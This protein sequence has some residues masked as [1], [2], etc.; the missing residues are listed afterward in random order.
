M[1]KK[2]RGFSLIEMLIVI[3]IACVMLGGI[4]N[5]YA[6]M[7]RSVKA[8]REQTIIRSLTS[9]YL[10]IVRNLPYSQVGTL[11]GNPS[12]SLADQTNPIQVTIQGVLYKI[13]YEVTYIDDTADGTI[14]LATDVAPNDFKQVKMFIQNTATTVVRSFVTTVTPKGLEGLGSGGALVI[15]VFDSQGQPVS[16]AS[17]HIE[18]LALTPDIILD[19][20]TDA[21]GTWIEVALPASVNGYHIVS[22]K[23]GYSTDQTYPISGGNPN[24]IKPDSTILAGQITQVSFQ[25][26]RVSNLTIRTLNSTCQNLSNVDVNLTGAKLI[27]TSPN[28]KKF[29]QNLTSAAGQIALT[30]I[31]WD[32][33]T[34]ILLTGQNLMTLG[35]S[36][37]QQISV[38]ANSSQTYTMILGTQTP[39]SLLVIAKDASTG[40]ALQDATVHLHKANPVTDYDAFTG[41]SVWSQIDWSGGSGQATFTV[42]GKYFSDDGNIDVA[43]IPAGVRLQQISGDY[44]ATG[45]FISS[46]FDTGGSSNY[47]TISWQPT[48]QNPATTLKFQIATNNDNATWNFLGPDGTA[49]TYYT[50]PGSNIATAHDNDRYVRYKAILQTTDDQV[51]PVLTSAAINYVSGCFTPG[52]VSFSGLT[53]AN[54]YDLSV[55]LAGYTTT[56]IPGLNINGNQSLE[57]LLSP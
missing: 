52:Q 45:Q 11:V 9:N 36:P 14:L 54:D 3:F 21:T 43:G 10:E 29:D 23:A 37:I 32:A 30:N 46:T 39:H 20:S 33:Y 55:S 22:S 19:R 5:L 18:N 6:A 56:N 40:L 15:K 13:Y 16:G 49:A 44:V 57:V 42:P 12:G 50:V 7:T 2:N 17:V 51:T 1:L 25:I 34:P 28:V 4:I 41:G 48:S 26:D 47:T 35:T 8:G 27:G 31:E 53:A 24:P 38:L